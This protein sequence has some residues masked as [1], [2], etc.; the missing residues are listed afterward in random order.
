MIQIPINF[1]KFRLFVYKSRKFQEIR[2]NFVYLYTMNTN[3]HKFQKIVGICI[4]IIQ[5]CTNFGKFHGFV[6]N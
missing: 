3:L 4:Q 1:R 5:I 6:Y 2:T